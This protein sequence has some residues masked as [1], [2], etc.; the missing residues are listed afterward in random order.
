MFR[1]AWGGQEL[2]LSKSQKFKDKRFLVQ[3]WQF[4]SRIYGFPKQAQIGTASSRRESIRLFPGI[5]HQHY[6][7]DSGMSQHF[8]YPPDLPVP[9]D[10]GGCDHL[11]GLPLPEDILVPV[12]QPQA[13]GISPNS[14][15]EKVSIKGLSRRGVV[16]IFFYPRSGAPDE[17]VPEEWNAI[18]GARG[19]TPQNC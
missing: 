1:I 3:K 16:V 6:S 9:Q 2:C 19:C 15:D 17:I 13:P 5:G 8:S 11:V 10:D 12:T 4:V 7:F 18:P 14:G